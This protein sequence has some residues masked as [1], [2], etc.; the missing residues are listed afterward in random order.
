MTLRLNGS[1]S[2]YIE[3]DAPAVA[4]TR[5]LVLPTDSIQPGLV[6]LNTTTFSASS[7]VSVNNCFTSAYDNYLIVASISGSSDSTIRLRAA[8]SDATS[9]L[10]GWS[11][12]SG[13]QTG[14][15]NGTGASLATSAQYAYV[16]GV[17]SSVITNIN[18]PALSAFTTWS[19][20]NVQPTTA[21]KLLAGHYGATTSFD[22]FTVLGTSQ[23]GTI[24]VYGY[25]N[26]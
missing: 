22:G 26:S 3:I 16:A 12:V 18:S 15:V 13:N 24:R 11:V 10:Y 14:T 6:L 9:S 2:G 25:R 1:T 8:G 23:T 20:S 21:I 19:T 7:S 17:T 5:T 4:G